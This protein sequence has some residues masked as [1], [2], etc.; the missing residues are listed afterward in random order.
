[1]VPGGGSSSVAPA[2][3]R[4]EHLLDGGVEGHRGHLRHPVVVGN[5]V[6]ARQLGDDAGQAAMADGDRLGISGR[7]RGVDGVAEVVGMQAGHGR[8]RRP[9]RQ[10]GGQLAEWQQP[11]P[12]AGERVRP[13]RDHRRRPDVGADRVQPLR[14]QGGVKRQVA[15]ARLHDREDGA[16]HVDAPVQVDADHGLGAGADLAQVARE[17]IGGG[18]QLAVAHLGPAGD[19][20]HRVR[21]PDGLLGDDLVDEPV[22]V[23]AAATRA[24]ARARRTPASLA[25]TL[26]GAMSGQACS[27]AARHSSL[28]IT[29]DARRQPDGTSSPAR[30]SAR[31]SWSLTTTTTASGVVSRWLVLATN[32]FPCNVLNAR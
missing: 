22:A 18:V 28:A 3:Q 15:G 17:P 5:P 26:A 1:M 12:G 32:N 11:R 4:D 2:R 21:T 23:R 13:G 7:S 25:R 10:L 6:L 16:D 24:R 20:G 29:A 8:R 19:H 9:A 31:W 14:R 27:M 30:H